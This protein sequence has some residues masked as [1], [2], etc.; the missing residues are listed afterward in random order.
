[1]EFDYKYRLTLEESIR[2]IDEVYNAVFDRSAETGAITYLP[3]LYDYALR[4]MIAK[5]YG[6]YSPTGEADTDYSAAMDVEIGRIAVDKAQFKGIVSAL[7]EK[8]EMEKAAINRARLSVESR[9]DRLAEP[10][11]QAASGLSDLFSRIDV[12]KL[13]ANIA[14]IDM[15][16]LVE[17]Y[18]KSGNV[19]A[20]EE[21]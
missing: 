17:A 21:R 12:E 19:G 14:S 13:N 4:L 20:E 3:E 10:L 2:M 8:I 7:S 15:E 1:M 18:L 9:F 5:Y 16:H 11:A 6:G